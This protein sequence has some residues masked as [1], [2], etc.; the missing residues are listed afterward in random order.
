LNNKEFG[1]VQ[2]PE[3]SH[4]L[5]T[6]GWRKAERRPTWHLVLLVVLFCGLYF[7]GQ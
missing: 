1:A 2:Q 5:L 6:E 4:D 3:S 7:C